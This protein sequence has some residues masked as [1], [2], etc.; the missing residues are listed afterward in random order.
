MTAG[1]T[2]YIDFHKSKMTMAQVLHAVEVIK[3]NHPD[4][5]IYMDGDTFAIVG[6][7]RAVA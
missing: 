2:T 3:Q 4:E 5:E 6:K 7:K 1:L